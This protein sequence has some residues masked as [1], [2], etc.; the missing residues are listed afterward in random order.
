MIFEKIGTPI[1]PTLVLSGI[2]YDKILEEFLNKKSLKEITFPTNP[3]LNTTFNI[4]LGKSKIRGKSEKETTEDV[5]LT[6]INVS[7]DNTPSSLL[8]NNFWIR[9][10]QIKENKVT[11][12]RYCGRMKDGMIG[13]P[14]SIEANYYSDILIIKTE[15]YACNLSCALSFCIKQDDTTVVS[16][17]SLNPCR[18]RIVKMV[19]ELLYPGIELKKALDPDLLI[20]NGGTLS[21]EEYDKHASTYLK[22]INFEK[23]PQLND[24]SFIYEL[25]E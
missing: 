11:R 5:Y 23:N 10:E 15:Q 9:E 1:N 21:D 6:K 2:T 8:G 14:Y 12:C 19:Q 22:T 4:N 17:Y 24:I 13:I 3:F 20:C 7:E 25:D 16:K 18:T